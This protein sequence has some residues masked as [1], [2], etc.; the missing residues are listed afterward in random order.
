MKLVTAAVSTAAL[1][2]G[3][4]PAA[5]AQVGT[6][7]S[8]RVGSPMSG[9]QLKVRPSG[10]RPVRE[11]RESGGVGIEMPGV[12]RCDNLSY[13]FPVQLQR[14]EC[15]LRLLHLGGCEHIAL[16]SCA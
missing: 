2:V 15:R 16:P 3:F 6:P 13:H 11:R 14:S 7:A 5:Q 12:D 8:P 10:W 9:P 4:A 1:L